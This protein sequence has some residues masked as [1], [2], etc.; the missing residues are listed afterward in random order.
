[1]V[2][3]GGGSQGHLQVARGLKFEA[4]AL[5]GTCGTQLITTVGEGAW[6]VRAFM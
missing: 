4:L 5:T 2:G 3:L 1:M 6:G